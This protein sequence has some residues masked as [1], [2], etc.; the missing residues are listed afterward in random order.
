MKKKQ[1][2]ALIAAIAVIGCVGGGGYYFRDDILGLFGDGASTEDKVY[3]EKVSK[4]MNQVTGAENR[5]NGVVEA[6]DS[7][8]VNV[9]SSVPLRKSSLQ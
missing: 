7:Y 1:V 6:Q 5:Y 9:D 4:V 3:V 2:I 8:N